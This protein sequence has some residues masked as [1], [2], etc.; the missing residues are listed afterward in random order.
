[1]W[2]KLR[3]YIFNLSKN[4]VIFME[5]ESKGFKSAD[6]EYMR[7]IGILVG[8]DW[9]DKVAF[10]MYELEQDIMQPK[11]IHLA[12]QSRSYWIIM[13]DVDPE[14]FM[15]EIVDA[16]LDDGSNGDYDVSNIMGDKVNE[17]K[18]YLKKHYHA[19]DNMFAPSTPVAIYETNRPGVILIYVEK[20]E[21]R[22]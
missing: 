17:I 1:M 12:G 11:H 14:E 8:Y 3:L 15:K 13:Y 7:K 10:Q 6:E 4:G 9:L 16:G 19:T 5:Y 2:R 20:Q 22:I 21:G 18:E